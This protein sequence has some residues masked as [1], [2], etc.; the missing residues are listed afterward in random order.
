MNKAGVILLSCLLMAGTAAAQIDLG[1][2]E[3]KPKAE[4]SLTDAVS[5][6]TAET[7][8]EK[9][10]EN[11]NGGIFSFMNFSFLKSRK[12]PKEYVRPNE[13]TESFVERVTRQA[14]EGDV[15]SQLVLG[16]MYL[17]GESG[18]PVDYKKAFNYYSMA[19]A[20][21]DNIAI[22]N[23]GSLYF[24]G[25]GTKKDVLKAAT[26]FDKAAKLGNIEA[27]VNLA[28][29]YISSKNSLKNGQEAIR[30]FKQAAEAGNPTAK[31][32]LG[33][34]YYKGYMIKKDLPKAVSLIREAANANYDDAQ[35][36]LAVMYLNGEGITKNYGNA[37]KYLYKAVDQG[38][39]DAMVTLGDILALGTVYN[40]DLYRAHIL[41]NLAAVRGASRAPEKRDV[42][43]KNMKIEEILQAQAEAEKYIER[44]SDLTSYIKK[45][46]GEKVRSYVDENIS[47]SPQR[48]IPR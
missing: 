14:E 5:E 15:D 39:V 40:K 47:G 3:K 24:S 22:N 21:N 25:I 11:D 26:L 13:K 7:P 32:M 44:Q 18:V 45:T 31:F 43:E 42:L 2:G 29:I 34:A 33:Y 20:Q 19:A 41:F 4:V 8:D 1:V 9:V 16:Y 46:F 48:N 6:K 28:F 12:E 27:S 36:V 23:L 35:Y 10:S 38:N 37:V 17:Y 30:L